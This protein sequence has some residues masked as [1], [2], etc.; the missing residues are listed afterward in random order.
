MTTKAKDNFLVS[1]PNY[2]KTYKFSD[3]LLVL[4]MKRTQVIMNKPS[5]FCLSILEINKTVMY[6]FHY[7]YLKSKLCYMDRD[8]FIIYIKIESS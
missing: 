1:E 2:N 6:E 4:E 7:D 5:Y 8:S 3:N